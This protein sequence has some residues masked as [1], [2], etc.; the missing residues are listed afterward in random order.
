MRAAAAVT[1]AALLAGCASQPQQAAR[2]TAHPAI[3]AIRA[4]TVPLRNGSSG[5]PT[6]GIQI[7]GTLTNSGGSA[8][9]CSPTEFLLLES[10]NNAIAPVSA[11][12]SVPRIAPK[13]SA[14]FTATFST[15]QLAHLQLRFEHPDGTYESHPLTVPSA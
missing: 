2:V 15:T 1:A 8:L 5:A 6:R 14:T 4:Q 10:G 13:A 9:R 3:T 12:C 7:S 11:W